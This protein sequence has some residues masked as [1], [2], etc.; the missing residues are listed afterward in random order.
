MYIHTYIHTDRQTDRHTYTYIYIYIVSPP[1]TYFT[2]LFV[3][4]ALLSSLAALP[5]SSGTRN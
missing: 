2:C 3:P 4:H 5:G 1:F